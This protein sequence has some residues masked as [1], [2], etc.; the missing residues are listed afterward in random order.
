MGSGPSIERRQE[1]CPGTTFHLIARRGSIRTQYFSPKPRTSSSRSVSLRLVPQSP[2]LGRG[3]VRHN[4][5]DRGKTASRCGYLVEHVPTGGL[6][7]SFDSWEAVLAWHSAT[8][9]SAGPL[10]L[11]PSVP[12]G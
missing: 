12:S 4:L 3:A 8:V 1:C 11:E 7:E 6:H 9:I 2:L 5:V 10:M